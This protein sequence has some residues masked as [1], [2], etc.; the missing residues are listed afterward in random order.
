LADVA[1]RVPARETGHVQ[2]C[3]LAVE[4]LLALLAERELYPDPA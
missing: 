1:I 3:H 4:Q 2:E